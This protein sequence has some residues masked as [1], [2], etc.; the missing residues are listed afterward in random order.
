MW[1]CHIRSSTFRE[2]SLHATERIDSFRPSGDVN[3]IEG[4][5]TGLRKGCACTAVRVRVGGRRGLTARWPCSSGERTKFRVGERIRTLIPVESVRLEAGWFRRGR[6]WWNR[7]V[8]RIVLVQG[9]P[10]VLLVSVNVDG[11]AG[12]VRSGNHSL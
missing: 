5:V 1:L 2:G 6:G 8:G 11:E 4:T 12:T 3:V 10:P 7:W 9:K